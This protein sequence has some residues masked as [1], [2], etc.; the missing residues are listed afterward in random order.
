MSALKIVAKCLADYPKWPRG[1]TFRYSR[2][3][4]IIVLPEKSRENAI[5]I[6]ELLRMEIHKLQIRYDKDLLTL[7][8][9]ISSIAAASSAAEKLLGKAIEALETAQKQGTDKIRYADIASA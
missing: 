9:G 6:A 2:D 4:F 5:E 3:R 8:Y 1:M 7:S